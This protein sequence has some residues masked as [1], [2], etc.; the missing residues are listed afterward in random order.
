[1]TSADLVKKWYKNGQK[2][3]E[4]FNILNRLG[5]ADA[6]LEPYSKFESAPDWESDFLERQ[7]IYFVKNAVEM[8][9]VQRNAENAQEPEPII[10]LKYKMKELWKNYSMVHAQLSTTRDR[11]K[12]YRYASRIMR[13][14]IPALD[15]IYKKIDEWEETGQLPTIPKMA[16]PEVLRLKKIYSLRASISRYRKILKKTTDQIERMRIE[17]RISDCQQKIELL[18]E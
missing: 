18:N 2:F 6:R 8:H 10:Y 11:R 12:L 4:G 17:V 15:D 14:I 1:M 5:F 9:D 7:L 13:E 3:N 16:P